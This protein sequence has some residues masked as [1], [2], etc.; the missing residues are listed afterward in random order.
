MAMQRTGQITW[1]VFANDAGPAADRADVERITA[2]VP[3]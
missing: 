2:L 3:A 1:C